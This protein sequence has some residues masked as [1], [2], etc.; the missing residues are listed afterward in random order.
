VK[1]IEKVDFKEKGDD[2]NVIEKKKPDFLERQERRQR[3]LQMVKK[4]IIF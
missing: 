2:L 3:F 4:V 1:N